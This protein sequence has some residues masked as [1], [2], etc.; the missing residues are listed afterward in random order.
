MKKKLMIAIT[1]SA[2]IGILLD[3]IVHVFIEPS[4]ALTIKLYL[5]FTIQSNLI[6]FIYFLLILLDEKRDKGRYRSMFGGVLIYIFITMSVFI[7]FLQAIFHPTGVGFFGNLF[8]HYI[9]P[10]L[11]ITYFIYERQNYHFEY[12]DV[13]L[14]LIYP[15]SYIAF[16][17]ILGSLTGDYLYPFFQVEVVGIL[18]IVI[19]MS[20]LIILF[21]L[22]SFLVMKMVSKD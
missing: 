14:W 7:I 20:S 9:T 13:L 3:T 17:I 21:L 8:V 6:V 12:K 11:V 5:Y 2:F 15:L 10:G 22:L 19:A 4:I 1:V 18:G 16:V